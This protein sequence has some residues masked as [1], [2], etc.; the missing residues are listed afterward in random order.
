MHQK[1]YVIFRV[2]DWG[3]IVGVT[4]D[5]RK[6]EDFLVE[7]AQ[8]HER[9]E[10]QEF[11]LDGFVGVRAVERWEARGRVETNRIDP[12]GPARMV[13]WWHREDH[14]VVESILMNETLGKVYPE[15]VIVYSIISWE[16]A[17][18]LV[19]KRIKHWRSEL[20]KLD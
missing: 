8:A 10:I 3:S 6:A 14:V 15:V 13:L 17:V 4:L 11:E 20:D 7:A 12:V 16:H 18:S 9:L 19:W 5:R 2:D 1:A